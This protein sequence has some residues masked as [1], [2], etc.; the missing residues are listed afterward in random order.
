[1]KTEKK[2]YIAPNLTVVTFKPER[3]YCSSNLNMLVFDGVLGMGQQ[4]SE[5]GNGQ[6][7]WTEENYSGAG[8][9]DGAWN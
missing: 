3:G 2:T 4:A 5:K 8:W 7:V 1:M 6:E 9:S